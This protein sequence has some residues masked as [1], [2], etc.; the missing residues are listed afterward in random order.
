MREVELVG[1]TLS[2]LLIYSAKSV[3]GG[4]TKSKIARNRE[5]EQEV[6]R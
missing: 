5:I 1:K 6:L 2:V 4:F 3:D